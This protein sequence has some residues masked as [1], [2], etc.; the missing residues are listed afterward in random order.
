MFSYKLMF[1]VVVRSIFVP[2]ILE[3]A[4]VTR[5]RSG[6]STLTLHHHPGQRAG[7]PHAAGRVAHVLST[8]VCGH[9]VQDETAGAR[10]VGCDDVT[11]VILQREAV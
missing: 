2:T 5:W 3:V 10:P 1:L 7:V 4:M 8:V 6:V 9:T 11:G